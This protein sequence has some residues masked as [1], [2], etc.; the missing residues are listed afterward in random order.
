LTKCFV[1]YYEVQV[2]FWSSARFTVY[3]W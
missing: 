1:D 3:Y 2:V